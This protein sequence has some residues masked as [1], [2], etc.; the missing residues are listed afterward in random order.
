MGESPSPRVVS[1]AWAIRSLREF[2]LTLTDEDHSM[3]RVATDRGIFC[4]GF[5]KLDDKELRQHFAGIVERRP[6]VNR[7]QLEALGN[8]WEL[9][10]QTVN[11]LPL[12]CDVEQK[13]H[14]TCGG[15]DDLSNEDLARYCGELLGQ[16]V[17]VTPQGTL[18][19]PASAG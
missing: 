4:Q 18:T 17:L 16:D 3:C 9:A 5:R 13:E 15:W 11:R 1:R 10:R 12:A 2:L 14:G 8:Q 6:A 19:P 7:W